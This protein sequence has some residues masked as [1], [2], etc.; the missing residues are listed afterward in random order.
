MTPEIVAPIP[1]GVPLPKLHY[2]TKFL[3]PNSKIP[4]S[5]PGPEVTG[6]KPLPPPPSSIS[7][8]KLMDSMKP[9][10]PLV[11]QSG[12]GG[13][14]G[15]GGGQGG[16]STGGGGGIGGGGGGGGMVPQ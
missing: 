9:E 14:G 10:K 15:Y 6:A 1:A 13:G 2:P 3:T 7:I 4:M 12:T 5:N 8:E 11:L 16:L